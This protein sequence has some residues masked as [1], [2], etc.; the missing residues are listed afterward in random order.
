MPVIICCTGTSNFELIVSQSY[1][2]YLLS[3]LED[4]E[5]EFSETEA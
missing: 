4:A 2:D 3:W 5:L 1:A